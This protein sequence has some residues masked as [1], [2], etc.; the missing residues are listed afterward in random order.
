MNYKKLCHIARENGY[1]G[2]YIF[3]D[4]EVHIDYIDLIDWIF[5]SDFVYLLPKHIETYKKT[6]VFNHLKN[7]Y[8]L[9]NIEGCI[10]K[11]LFEY[12]LIKWFRKNGIYIAILPDKDKTT[13]YITIKD[14]NGEI[15]ELFVDIESYDLAIGC[16]FKCLLSGIWSNQK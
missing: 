7:W 16:T 4:K 15:V 8:Y 1:K 11:E 6:L 14:N 2:N 10:I 9:T 3:K 13:F 12:N 5:S